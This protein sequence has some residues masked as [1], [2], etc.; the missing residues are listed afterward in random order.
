MCG[1][2]QT[3]ATELRLLGFG[4][5]FQMKCLVFLFF[6]L[7][8]IIT[9]IGN[10]LIISLTLITAKL[11]SPMYF[12]LGNLSLCEILFTTF[13]LP[14]I[15]YLVWNN[16]GSISMDYCFLQ[17]YVC[18]SAG[19]TEILLLTIMA[20]DRYLAI[21]YP[22][23]YPSL[24]NIGTCSYLVSM[25]WLSGFILA[26]FPNC[27]MYKLQ[28]CHTDTIDVIFCETVCILELSSTDTYIV[29]LEM[30]VLVTVLCLFP[31]ILIIV[32]Y[33]SIF[34]TV[35][36]ISSKNWRMKTFSTCSS[37]LTSVFMYFGTLFIIYLVPSQLY[38]KKMK[39]VV[40]L[41]YTV[42]TP[43]LNPLIYSL[44]NKE[45]KACLMS[46]ITNIK[47]NKNSVVLQVVP[48]LHT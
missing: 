18:G 38:S 17:I 33:V 23:R 27:E 44:R 35:I 31:F 8:Y 25:A 45:M 16:G 36:T 6:L 24:M 26:S 32:S 4:N 2:N 41:A 46:Y 20:L 34:S 43:L 47:S 21:C 5:L 7:L 29:K 19:I 14:H 3:R 42:L 39:K 15:L 48:R 30:L 11:N 10:T 13:V 12:F 22:L 37:H 1:N 9:L 40:S 28:I